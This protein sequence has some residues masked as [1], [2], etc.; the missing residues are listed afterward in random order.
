MFEMMSYMLSDE[1]L[2]LIM[3]LDKENKMR[4]LRALLRDPDL[5]EYAYDPL[6]IRTNYE[7]ARKMMEILEERKAQSHPEIK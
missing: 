2:Q 1:L 7:V 3:R 6:G 5:E 4:L